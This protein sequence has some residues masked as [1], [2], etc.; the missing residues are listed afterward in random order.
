M[1]KRRDVAG[2]VVEVAVEVQR[3]VEGEREIVSEI[4]RGIRVLSVLI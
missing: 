2:V 4:D 1:R 3:G